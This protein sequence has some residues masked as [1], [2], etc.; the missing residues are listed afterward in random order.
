MSSPHH[1]AT[2]G[3]SCTYRG[4][5]DTPPL[6]LPSRKTCRRHDAPLG[7]TVSFLEGR[8]TAFPSRGHVSTPKKSLAMDRQPTTHTR[9]PRSSGTH[10]QAIYAYTG[11]PQ[12]R[13]VL[14]QTRALPTSVSHFHAATTTLSGTILLVG[15][16]HVSLPPSL[17]PEHSTAYHSFLFAFVRPIKGFSL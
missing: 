4:Y 3:S 1:Y 12:V 17:S 8:V 10:Q 7:E 6:S 14:T 11:I 9:K 5:T 16:W 15:L 13:S 2:E